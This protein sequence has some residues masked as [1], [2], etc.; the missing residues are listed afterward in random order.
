M[1]SPVRTLSIFAGLGL[2]G[3]G[4]TVIAGWWLRSP[5]LVQLVPGFAAMVFN[6]ALS[7]MLCGLALLGLAAERRRLALLGSGAV[8]VLA[9][10]QLP[11]TLLGYSLHLDW[12][13]LHGWMDDGNR[14]PGRMSI[15]TNLCFLVVSALLVLESTAGPGRYRRL[16]S[17]L[18]IA[19]TLVPLL[20]LLGYLINGRMLY[21]QYLFNLMAAHTAAAFILIGITLVSRARPERAPWGS[22]PADQRIGATAGIILLVVAI[23]A[24]LPGYIGLQRQGTQYL[25]ESLMASLQGHLQLVATTLD[26]RLTRSR[27]ALSDPEL[28]G[29]AHRLDLDPADAGAATAFQA[30]YARLQPFGFSSI[31]WRSLRN[32]AARSWG[33][34]AAPRVSLD[35][36]GGHGE[37][38]RLLWDHGLLLRLEQV[39]TDPDGRPVEVAAEQPLPELSR[40]LIDGDPLGETAELRLCLEADGR[41][42]CLPSALHPIP[43]VFSNAQ[44]ALAPLRPGAPVPSSVVLSGTSD[45]GQPVVAAYATLPGYGLVAMLRVNSAEL[46]APLRESFHKAAALLAILAFTGAWMLRRQVQPLAAE[47]LDAQHAAEFRLA[48]LREREAYVQSLFDQ[49][50]QAMLVVDDGGQIVRANALA[51]RIFGER[52]GA[53]AGRRVEDLMPAAFRG[54]HGEHLRRF[55]EN[56]Q[57]RYMRAGGHVYGQRDG[58]SFPLE[59]LLSPV[60]LPQRRLVIALLRD[61]TDRQREDDERRAS[62]LRFRKTME[63]APIG[64]ALVSLQ[65]QWME[66][67][68]AICEITG[69]TRDELLASTF[70]DITHPDDLAADLRHVTD[71]VAGRITSYQMEKRYLRKDG[72]VV[73]VL[74]A[75]SLVRTSAGDPD[76]FISQV[77]DID[78]EYR[79]NADLR[80]ALAMQRAIFDAADVSIISTGPD[81][82]IASFN[83]AAERMLGRSAEAMI[84]QTTPECLHDPLEIS[85]RARELAAELERPIDGA[86]ETFVAMARERQGADQREW[87]Y[88]RSD[89]TRF[90][91]LLS[92]SAIRDEAGA[93]TGFLG[94]ATDISDR[95]RQQAEIERALA[96]KETLLKEIY[97]RVKNNLQVI[98][99]LLNL[100]LRTLGPGAARDALVDSIQRV[101]AMALVHEKLYQSKNL[102]SVAAITYLRELA[103]QLASGTGLR[104][105]GIELCCEGDAIELGPEIAVPLGLVVNELVGNAIK[106]GFPAGRKGRIGVSLRDQRSSL[107]LEVKDDGVGFRVEE[108]E[109]RQTLGLTLVRMLCRQLDS[110]FE[111]QS[112]PGQGTTATLDLPWGAPTGISGGS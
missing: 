100:Q 111:L 44:T 32:D 49:A 80:Q 26:Y 68:G 89:G 46:Y 8:L 55:F 22:L 10:L 79:A 29:L 57:T 84:G 36:G 67:N 51:E 42:H 97:H 39:W 85:A 53:L 74:L 106:H 56:P 9:L 24:A 15:S 64:M 52:P 34:A 93:V 112:T 7:F 37:H 96:E 95:K 19:V 69:Y 3:L 65:G 71:L 102:A 60:H 30:L 103:S 87:T 59:V 13:A 105:R 25:G 63:H 50:P 73:W 5:E 101:R 21:N 12:P 16:R 83:R 17:T 18:G 11:E 62:E 58:E 48:Q 99:S 107:R 31:Q 6:T 108:Q 76:Y 110:R 90:P 91:V 92:V 14:H 66:V 41:T 75:V 4:S 77:K 23:A 20:A 35:L 94:V 61:I 86:I 40:L 82:V 54:G 27:L 28:V 109:G 2:T 43:E 81:G 88:I 72:R 45:G 1:N 78:S 98:S 47:L 104:E 33:L 70:Q 38:I